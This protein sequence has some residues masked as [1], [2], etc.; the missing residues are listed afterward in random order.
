MIELHMPGDDRVRTLDEL[1][2]ELDA[3]ERIILWRRFTK[4]FHN[5][6]SKDKRKAHR[7]LDEVIARVDHIISER[8][9]RAA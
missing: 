9:R 3:L 5:P 7:L 6:T 2:T 1:P 8:D 4:N